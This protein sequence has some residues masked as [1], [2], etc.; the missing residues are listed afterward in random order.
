MRGEEEL[1]ILRAQKED[2]N[3][4]FTEHGRR[5]NIAS[6]LKWAVYEEGRTYEVKEEESGEIEENEA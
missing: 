3:S 4:L 2:N 6:D 5:S 1:L